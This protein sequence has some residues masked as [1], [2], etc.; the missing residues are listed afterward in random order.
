MILNSLKFD[1]QKL[2]LVS[3][4]LVA[5]TFATLGAMTQTA[6][7]ATKAFVCKHPDTPGGYGALDLGCDADQFGD[8]SRIKLV[9]PSLVMDRRA[10]DDAFK[11][12][13]TNVNSTIKTIAY[14]Y[15]LAR[16]PDAKPATLAYFTNVAVVV[17]AHESKLSHYRIAKDDRYK[18]MTGDHL[19]SHGIMQVNQNFHANK[20]L[21]SSFDFV[22]NVVAGLDT[23]FNEWNRAVKASC[24]AGMNGKAPTLER[25]LQN[26]ARSAYSAYNGG[27]GKLCRYSTPKMKFAAHDVAFLETLKTRPYLKWIKDNRQAP[28]NVKCLMEGDTLCAMAKPAR[29]QFLTS[30]PL[31]LAD[32]RT[33]MTLNGKSLYCAADMRVFSCLSK[34][35]PETLENDPLRLDKLP[36]GT[37]INDLANREQICSKAVQGLIPVGSQIILQKDVV[38]REEVGGAPI[39]SLKMTRPYQVLDYDIRLGGKSERYY[40]IATPGGDTGWIFGGEDA[41]RDQWI[42]VA[43]PAQVADLQRAADSAKAEKARLAAEKAAAAAQAAV[44]AS[45]AAQAA[46]AQKAAAVQKAE[47][48]Q[49]I[50]VTARR[51]TPTPAP[52]LTVANPLPAPAISV[53]P[54]AKDDDDVVAPILPVA[55]SIIEIVAAEIA[56]RESVGENPD[57]LPK[58]QLFKGARVTVEEVVT[59]GTDNDIYLRV[60]AGSK[61]GWIRAGHTSPTVTVQ[62]WV[63]L[64]K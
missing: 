11:E 57:K 37:Q 5:S 46:A 34:V 32:G 59:R 15:Y 10:D 36:P 53:S 54:Q 39:G 55:G 48:S 62:N 42:R 52:T 19:V 33:C 6:S 8:V 20:E 25:M 2:S 43:T 41:D 12:Y 17:A 61:V 56:L 40:K 21:D 14:K 51:P 29:D 4:V 3:C 9:Y 26:R 23:Y 44:Q 35:N 63:K 28:V 45:A 31:L 24:F 47:E 49:D 58:D 27:P 1:W 30:R 13:I 16:I 64:W 7:A 60:M 22:G 18:L 38:M 50:V